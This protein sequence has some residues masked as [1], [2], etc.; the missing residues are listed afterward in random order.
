MDSA[1]TKHTSTQLPSVK[2]ISKIDYVN[3]SNSKTVTFNPVVQVKYID[4][5]TQSRNRTRNSK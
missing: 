1:E 5:S 4:T 3:V 2:S